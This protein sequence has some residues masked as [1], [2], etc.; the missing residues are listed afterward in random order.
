MKSITIDLPELDEDEMEITTIGKGR[1]KGETVVV[2][3]GHHKWIIIDSCMKDKRPLALSY[4]EK[5]GYSASD[6]ISIV[7]SHWHD[8][9]FKGLPEL[10][11]ECNEADFYMSDVG[12]YSGYMRIVFDANAIDTDE[13]TGWK[14]LE[15][16]MK[17]LEK[18]NEDGKSRHIN[19]VSEGLYLHDIEDLPFYIQALTPTPEAK[20]K[21]DTALLKY[22]S[23]A[24]DVGELVNIKE[25]MCSLAFSYFDN[26]DNNILIGGDLETNLSHDGSSDKSACD[27]DCKKHKEDGWCWIRECSRHYAKHKPYSFVKLAHHGS[28][29]AFCPKQW[30]E[31]FCENI[32]ATGTVF[33]ADPEPLPRKKMAEE[34]LKHTTNLYLTYIDVDDKAKEDKDAKFDIDE[35]PKIKILEKDNGDDIP[36]I[37]VCR[38]KKT[39]TDWHVYPFGNAKQ[40]KANM[41]PDYHKKYFK[42]QK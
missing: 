25:N 1:H 11:E 14:C 39:D 22:N 6:V 24:K 26:E 42:Q 40:F 33:I 5:I 20:K 12:D 31:D 34:F 23:E 18:E 16:C 35:D 13:G 29:T 27:C 2:H 4:L 30:N 38:R 17:K 28:E 8:D 21:F 19:Y 9:H 32:Y 10:I 15:D 37:I 3:A 36:G 41:L 7:C